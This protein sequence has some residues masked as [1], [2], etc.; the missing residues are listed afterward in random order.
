M[1]KGENSDPAK[2]TLE[3]IENINASH[4]LSL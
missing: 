1:S 2:F 3:N 4:G